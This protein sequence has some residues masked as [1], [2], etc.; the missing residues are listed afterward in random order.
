[1]ANKAYLDGEDMGLA[2]KEVSLLTLFAQNPEKSFSAEHLYEKAWGHGMAGY[3]QA[4]RKTISR[5]RSK[6]ENSGYKITAE[7]NERYIFERE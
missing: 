4:L 3:N 6:L 2:P 7:R 1:M 5:L